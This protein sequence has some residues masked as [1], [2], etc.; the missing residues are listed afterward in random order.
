MWPAV[1]FQIM[2]TEMII[3][4]ERSVFREVTVSVI[5]KKEFI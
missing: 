4:G 2:C 3:N 1:A 5:I